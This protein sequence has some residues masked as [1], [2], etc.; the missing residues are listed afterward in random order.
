MENFYENENKEGGMKS[1]YSNLP[2]FKNLL[3]A[4]SDWLKDNTFNMTIPYSP[5]P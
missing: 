1:Y 4:I 5:Q 2:F 3:E